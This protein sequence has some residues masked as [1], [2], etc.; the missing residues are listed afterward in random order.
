MR[1]AITDD[2]QAVREELAGYVQRYAAVHGIECEVSRYSSG[3]ALL[4]AFRPE[5]YDI[6][7]FDIDMPGTN[8]INTARRIREQDGQAV[9]L[10]IT[11]IAQYAINGYEVEALDYI[12]KPIGYHDFALKFERAER[13]AGQQKQDTLLLNSTEGIVPVRVQDIVCI[14]ANAHYMVYHTDRGAYRVR[15]SLR[16]HET[17]MADRHFSR[18]QRSFLINLARVERITSAGVEAGGETYSFGRPY[19]ESFMLDYMKYLGG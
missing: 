18:V 4:D 2:E 15:G 9:I 6:L 8:G 1:I 3:D 11:N 7:I 13:K 10:F 17:E 14:E 16:E 19:K 12:I 5:Y